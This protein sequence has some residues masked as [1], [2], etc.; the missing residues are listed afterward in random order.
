M[1]NLTLCGVLFVLGSC[2]APRAVTVEHFGVMREVMM[3]GKTEARVALAAYEKPGFYGVGAL[4]GLAGEV[5][6]DDGKVWIAAGSV[7]DP[8]AGAGSAQATLLTVAPVNAWRRVP[9]GGGDLAALECAIAAA[10]AAMPGGANQPVPFR[11]TTAFRSLAGHAARGACPHAATTPETEPDR[12]DLGDGGNGN[13]VGFYA[14]GREG[15]MTHHGTAIHAH[16]IG[17][18]A[19]DH[20]GNDAHIM[21]HVDSCVC[22]PEA[23]LFVPAW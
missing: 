20:S 15:E 6:I 12:F 13:L 4:E 8:R 9:F 3:E 19:G 11:V 10:V 2:A 21:G 17:S 22:G 23:K 16:W 1:N 14:P 18:I 5:L 7:L